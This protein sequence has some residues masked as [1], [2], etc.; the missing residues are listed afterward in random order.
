MYTLANGVYANIITH[1]VSQKQALPL[2]YVCIHIRNEFSGRLKIPQEHNY[3]NDSISILLTFVVLPVPL[4]RQVR[5]VYI[6]T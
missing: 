5:Y 1:E 2:Y 6:T 3:D 4:I